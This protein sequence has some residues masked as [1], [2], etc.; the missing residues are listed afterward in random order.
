[1]IHD[2]NAIW[3]HCHRL[4]VTGRTTISGVTGRSESLEDCGCTTDGSRGVVMSPTGAAKGYDGVVAK[5]R[6]KSPYRSEIHCTLRT[7]MINSITSSP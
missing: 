4:R 2:L 3:R 1:M 5:K 7:A 6:G